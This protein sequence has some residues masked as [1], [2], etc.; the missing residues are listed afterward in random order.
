MTAATNHYDVI[1][2]GA[3]CAGAATARLLAAAGHDVLLLDRLSVANDPLSTHG[4]ARGGVVQL[5][6]WGLLQ[7]VLDSGAPPIREVSFTLNDVETT[8]RVKNRAGVDL[9]VA[10]RRFL[11]DTLL[12]HH[13]RIAGATVQMG[14][15]VTALV[16]DDH[17]RICG[18][19]G[20]RADG[21]HVKLT[22]R[23]VIG[24][25]GL[26]ST[27]A[28][29]TGASVLYGFESDVALFYAYVDGV[30]WR[31]F[32]F[33]VSAGA[34][35]GV[36]P[37]HDGQAC[38]WLTRPTPL[39]AEVTRAGKRRQQ[40]FVAALDRVAPGL[41]ARVGAGRIVSSMRGWIAPA[42]YV[43]LA[44]GN[45]WSLVGDAGYYRDPITGHGITDAFRDAELLARAVDTALREP[46]L[47]RAVLGDYASTRN[48]A[49]F[50]TL[51]LTRKLATFPEPSHFVELQV[52]LSEALDREA[53][54]LAS[55]PTPVGALAGS[56]A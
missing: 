7:E 18:V 41:V 28:R 25:D 24:A 22:A 15:V 21:Q 49:L 29:H 31:G 36:F 14:L 13:A 38:V 50:E 17:G 53:Q 42:N 4:I 5:A 35:A 33:Y 37:T 26:R 39:M 9:F 2:I 56:T 44:A 16:R 43:K 19:I 55:M 54:M 32:E 12:V 23:H 47:E 48:A 40:V 6:R 52:Q 10:P 46:H 20:R 27:V 8:R 34:F 1:V 11:L 51:E 3:R 45:G 30:D